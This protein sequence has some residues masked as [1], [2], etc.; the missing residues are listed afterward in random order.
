[1]FG[2]GVSGRRR[3]RLG[4]PSAV[5]GR[6]AEASAGVTFGFGRGAAAAMLGLSV[7]VISILQTRIPS[8]DSVAGLRARR[9]GGGTRVRG[10]VL[11]GRHGHET[12]P[13]VTAERS[14]VSDFANSG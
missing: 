12:H 7:R 13:E 8:T 1:M 4:N 9:H 5:S 11:G 6:G 10:Q 2:L 3:W 14:Q